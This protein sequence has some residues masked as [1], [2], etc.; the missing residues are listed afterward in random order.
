MSTTSTVLILIVIL[1]IIFIIILV[2]VLLLRKKN[3]VNPTNDTTSE[4]TFKISNQGVS[5][6]E[7]ITNIK[8]NDNKYVSTVT[9]TYSQTD[10]SKTITSE[11]LQFSKTGRYKIQILFNLAKQNKAGESF[12]TYLFL[13][14]NS[15][16]VQPVS[17]N[18]VANV[19]NGPQY[20][21]YDQISF[22]AENGG[23]ATYD[24]YPQKDQGDLSYNYSPLVVFSYPT[25]SN[26][27]NVVYSNFFAL[28]AIFDILFEK[29]ILYIQTAFDSN[30][31][32]YKYNG[33]LLTGSGSIQITYLD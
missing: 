19:V 17:Y 8:Y 33:S 27:S 2:V 30:G 32:D 26:N 6:L 11:G 18:G 7:N 31:Q 20:L 5:S 24:R 14:Q 25:K 28:Y 15:S 16:K 13:S 23:L 12:N 9:T 10:A 1:V 3:P 22:C 29:E 4:G 21:Q